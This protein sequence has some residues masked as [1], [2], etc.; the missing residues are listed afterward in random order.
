MNVREIIQK[1]LDRE[2]TIE[3]AVTAINGL[4]T[5]A[6]GDADEVSRFNGELVEALKDCMVQI[7]RFDKGGCNPSLPSGGRLGKANH[8]L[9]M[10]RRLL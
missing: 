3:Q 5:K 4:V 8:A 1:L 2:I 9:R 7:E 6:T 10:E